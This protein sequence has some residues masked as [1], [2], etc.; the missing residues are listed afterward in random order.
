L[1]ENRGIFRQTELFIPNMLYSRNVDFCSLLKVAFLETFNW[2]SF[3]L[4]HLPSIFPFF[5]LFD[6]KLDLTWEIH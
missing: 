5:F 1:Q 3:I 6:R 4:V 2:F